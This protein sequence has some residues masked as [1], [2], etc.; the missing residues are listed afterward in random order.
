MMSKLKKPTV[1]VRRASDS[2]GA[3]RTREE[4]KPR[5][6]KTK[7]QP[8]LGSPMPE[9]LH[10]RTPRTMEDEALRLNRASIPNVT[11]EENSKPVAST[12]TT[13]P[14]VQHDTDT[15][16]GMPTQPANIIDD[17]IDRMAMDKVGA[18]TKNIIIALVNRVMNSGY[19]NT[20]NNGKIHLQS[21]GLGIMLT[22]IVVMIQPF[23]V[24]Y[25][26]S[27]VVLLGRL[28]KH[29][30]TWIVVVG[31]ISYVLN[32]KDAKH[33]TTGSTGIKP[34]DIGKPLQYEVTKSVP[35][36]PKKTQPKPSR[37]NTAPSIMTRATS[38]TRPSE[39]VFESE[40]DFLIRETENTQNIERAKLGVEGSRPPRD[41]FEQFMEVARKKEQER[42]MHQKFMDANKEGITRQIAFNE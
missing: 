15:N 10:T 18:F 22:S 21:F 35:S 17:F 40:Q 1:L 9:L 41:D 29:L 28:F 13:S 2:S 20:E 33:G 4:E 42:I 32:P 30:V 27:W 19:V 23:L 11:F 12:T 31:V 6:V 24:V 3:F 34:V 5:Q 16:K 37:K 36:S 14:Q 26:D 38:S 39:G 25:L 8:Q 7:S